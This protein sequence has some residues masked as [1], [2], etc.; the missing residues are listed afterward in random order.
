MAYTGAVVW[1]WGMPRDAAA[2]PA[3]AR[4]RAHFTVLCAL[5]AGL[6]AWVAALTMPVLVMSATSA[7]GGTVLLGS[8]VLVRQ[9]RLAAA[10]AMVVLTVIVTMAILLVEIGVETSRIG[11]V[12][13]MPLVAGAAAGAR[14]ALGAGCG[15]AAIMIGLAI[16]TGCGWQAPFDLGD[17][18]AWRGLVRQLVG[19]TA[20]TVVLRVG[21]DKVQAQL[22]SHEAAL[23]ASARALAEKNALLES[24]VEERS[25]LLSRRARA[26][27]GLARA[28]ADRLRAPLD[29]I[30]GE[31]A[32]LSPETGAAHEVETARAA[33]ERLAIM[34]DRLLEH[35]RL[36]A[37][38]EH[39]TVELAPLV[40]AVV[41]EHA[42]AAVDWRIGALPAVRGDATLLRNAVQNLVGNA[43]KFSR[44]RDPAV[45]EIGWDA[46]RAVL[47][48]RDNGVG[49]DARYGHKLFKPFQRLHGVSEFEG[50]GV[51]LANVRRV[52]EAHGGTCWAES[53]PGEGAAFYLSLP[54]TEGAT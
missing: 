36:G 15:L 28:V 16:A 45:I 29:A 4:F 17:E 19:V 50:V 31:L 30:G 43:V 26:R 44:S 5:V 6:W 48:V 46:S 38:V 13:G 39:A 33:T 40:A 12:M 18:P 20:L 49:F 14:G 11:A 37:T 34:I 24:R 35:A 9:G 53:E 32:D 8:I 22:A 10:A 27:E 2:L 25:A 41:A 7:A 54:S 52:A 51:G 23:E 3:P 1:N 42:D 21:Y 47:W